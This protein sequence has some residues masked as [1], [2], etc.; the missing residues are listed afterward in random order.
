[1]ARMAD[2]CRCW[3]VMQRMFNLGCIDAGAYPAVRRPHARPRQPSRAVTVA[4]LLYTAH[5]LW[6]RIWRAHDGAD[7]AGVLHSA[8]LCRR[9]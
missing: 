8:V 3:P 2:F 5:S 6:P 9:K 1:M 4:G 7:S